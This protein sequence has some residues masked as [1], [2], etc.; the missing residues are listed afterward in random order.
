MPGVPFQEAAATISSKPPLSKAVYQRLLPEFKSLAFTIT[1]IADFDVMQAVRDELAT[2]PLGGDWDTI[3]KSIEAKM[4]PFLNPVAA[5]KRAELLLRL[6]G[7]QAYGAANYAKLEE[8]K[9]VFPFRQYQSSQDGRVRASHAA[10]NKIVLPADHPFWLKHTPPWE[11]NCRCDVVGLMQAD[12]DDLREEEKNLPEARK[13]VLEGQALKKFEQDAIL[14]RDYLTEKERNSKSS[15]MYQ[16]NVQTPKE[17]DGSGYEWEPATMGM[18]LKTVKARYDAPTFSKWESWAR[19][20]KVTGEN[21]TVWEWVSKTIPPKPA[22]PKPVYGKPAAKPKT[23]GKTKHPGTPVS[24]ALDLSTLKGKQLTLVKKCTAA[25]NAVHGDGSLKPGAVLAVR[26]TSGA[27][28]LTKYY[29]E[30]GTAGKTPYI[31]TVHEVGHKLDYEAIKAARQQNPT[32]EA[33]WKAVMKELDK[34]PEIIQLR[35]EL[36][37]AYANNNWHAAGRKNYLLD[38]DEIWARAYAQYIAEESAVPELLADLTA[39]LSGTAGYEPETQWQKFDAPRAAI[40]DLL[41]TLNW[42]T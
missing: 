3:K 33:K 22:G 21:Y 5:E 23:A 9:D 31:Q 12:V 10:L 40:T 4:S 24:A 17:R 29:I 25:V 36:K 18:D 13:Y 30:Y 11:Y 32:V 16:F 34:T 8:H 28:Y 41:K 37:A 19:K 14:I 20:T 6:H 1:G 35:A 15:G 38:P 26:G 27:Y 2:L 42:K 39:R 7:F